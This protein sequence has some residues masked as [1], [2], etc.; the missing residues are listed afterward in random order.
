MEV[1]VVL[2]LSLGMSLGMGGLVVGLVWFSLRQQREQGRRWAEACQQLGLTLTGS[3]T[4]GLF[5]GPRVSLRQT[6][7]GERAGLPVQVGMR[8]VTSGSGKNRQTHYY[9]YAKAFFPRSLELGLS[10]TPTNVVAR[11]FAALVGSRDLEVGDARIDPH[12]KI[13]AAEPEAAQ[14][15]LR[16]PYLADALAVGASGAFEPY[17]SD[18]ELRYE[19]RGKCLDAGP[20]G[21]A[22]DQAIDLARRILAA[23]EEIG[24][25]GAEDVV[26]RAWRP[27]AEARGLALDVDQTRMSG[28]VEGVHVE[29][30]AQ[31]RGTRRVTVFTVRFDRAL[32]V[33][34]KLTREGALHGIGKLF[35]MVD[36]ETG[37]PA[38]DDR[39]VVKG[40]P[41]DAVRALLTPEVRSQLVSLQQ[42]AELLEVED[43]RLTA[44]VGWLIR[45]PAW[46]DSGLVTLARAGAALAGVAAGAGPYRR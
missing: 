9:S 1:V 19:M 42:H 14:A 4:R 36:I 20:L 32:G 22:L 45:D 25:T 3:P 5:S 29:V 35:G 38:F 40:Q 10:V 34:L 15:L 16:V 39:F 33:G 30:D 23:R 11:A 24:P 28:R 43:D 21:A 41:A 13:A 37:D 7:D 6:M 8:I 26:D 18:T 27:I 2:C 44:V 46:I 12:Y 17:V 31:L